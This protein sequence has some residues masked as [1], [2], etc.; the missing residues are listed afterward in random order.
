MATLLNEA[1]ARA[2]RWRDRAP[3]AQRLYPALSAGSGGTTTGN[4]GSGSG[5]TTTAPAPQSLAATIY[6]NLPSAGQPKERSHE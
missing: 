4:A 3:V 2:Q 5:G 6:P 1:L